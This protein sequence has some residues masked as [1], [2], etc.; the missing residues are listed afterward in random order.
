LVAGEIQATG[1]EL[2]ARLADL[3]RLGKEPMVVVG[4]LAAAGGLGGGA[5]VAALALAQLGVI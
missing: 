1:L 2:A 5:C 4:R 3:C